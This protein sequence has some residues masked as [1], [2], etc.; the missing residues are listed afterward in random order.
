[1]LISDTARA[2]P[3]FGQ[4]A[5]GRLDVLPTGDLGIQKGFQVQHRREGTAML[6]GDGVQKGNGRE[7]GQGEAG[8][9]RGSEGEWPAA[10]A[11]FH[12]LKF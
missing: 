10:F 7:P 1:M 12:P 8:R 4:F 6:Q 5:L 3:G 11:L 2:P 9:F